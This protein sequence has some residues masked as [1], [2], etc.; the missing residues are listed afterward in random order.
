[1]R[2]LAHCAL[3]AAEPSLPSVPGLV[4]VLHYGS[5]AI[6]VDRHTAVRVGDADGPGGLPSV[7]GDAPSFAVVEA[8]VG[9]AAP[10]PPPFSLGRSFSRMA[11]AAAHFYKGLCTLPC[12]K[13]FPIVVCG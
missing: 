1:M 9:V 11:C 2:S 4:G 7:S 3:T 5:D 6:V 13:T 12:A 10:K 8:G